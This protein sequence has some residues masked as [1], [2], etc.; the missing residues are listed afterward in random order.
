MQ[1]TSR[2]ILSILLVL[3]IIVTTGV[4]VSGS[5]SADTTVA[6]ALAQGTIDKGT[7]HSSVTT[8]VFT[9]ELFNV[10]EY[11][12]VTIASG[13]KAIYHVYDSSN[14]WLGSSAWANGTGA[15]TFKTADMKNI[16]S[17]VVYFRVVIA[18]TDNSDITAASAANAISL[19]ASVV[20][21]EMAQGTIDSSN[22]SVLSSVTTRIYTKD[23]LKIADYEKLTLASGYK[24]WYHVYDA[25][26]KWVAH[27]NKW[28]EGAY[29]AAQ[30]TALSSS[31]VYFRA[32]VGTTS[33]VTFLPLP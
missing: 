12:S 25:D 16:A 15:V 23:L 2:K 24:A 21:P 10:D 1:N 8:R 32:A 9:K 18:L 6:P 5:V 4:F 31:A 27:S 20:T 7:I 30:L 14:T 22:G 33:T 29:T 28:V 13:Y 3:T 26:G 17:N 19:A 11:K